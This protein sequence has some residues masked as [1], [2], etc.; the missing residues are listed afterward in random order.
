MKKGI[1][2]DDYVLVEG[3][4]TTVNV[5]GGVAYDSEDGEYTGTAG[6]KADNYFGMTGGTLTITNSGSGGKGI[7]AGNYSYDS[8]NH[9]LSDSY[10]SGGT[11]IIKTT[12]RESNDVSCKG[13]KIGWATKSGNKVTGYAGNMKISGGT[14]SVTCSYSEGFEVKGDLTITGGETYVYS[15]GDDAINAGA[16][17]NMSGGYVYGYATQNDAIDSN[18]D[19]KISGGYLYAIT[20]KGAPDVALDANTEDGY[21]LYI[22]NGAT[23]VAYGGLESNYVS[24]STIYSMS[25]TANGWN[26]IKN[27]SGNII[28]AFK[29]PSGLSS[30]AVTGPSISTSA[31]K[32]VT[33]SSSDYKCGGMWATGASGG[34]S[35]TLGTYKQQEGQG[36]NGHGPGGK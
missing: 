34:S 29:A 25:A 33:V 3:G 2:S 21:K 26:A 19:L 16:E 27:S 4:T 15:T 20:T 32:G 12:G 36:G 23:V 35:V 6:V 1:S 22:Y 7:R 18:H 11:L 31:L 13:I 24:T 28:A 9:T 14:I 8:T 5:T 30:F 10:I 17:L